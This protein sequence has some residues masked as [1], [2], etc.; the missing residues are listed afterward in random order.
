MF[1]TPQTL[2][3][4]I[5]LG[6]DS[7][8]EL[9][10]VRFRGKKIAGPSRDELAN[11]LAAFANANG[12]VMVLGVDDKTR[13]VAGIP[14]EKLDDVETYVRQI[15]NDAVAP[16]LF[17]KIVRMELPDADGGKRPILKI[18]I[19]QS[20]FVHEGPGGYF[21]RLGSS[22]R[23]MP[24]D[25]LARLF[26]Q[27]SQ[28]RLIRF[29]EQPAPETDRAT[30][31]EYLWRRFIPSEET[32]PI[33]A[34]KKMRLLTTDDNGAERASVAGV[35]MCSE[36]PE[37]ILPNAYIEAVRYRG[38]QRDADHQSAAARITG[39]LDR[40]VMHALSFVRVNMR[41]AAVKRPGRVEFPQFSI[42]AVFEALVNAVGHRDYTIHGS[43]IRLF[44]YDDRL[45]LFS[46]GPPPNTVTPE[47]LH[48]RQA[49]RNELI[50][51]LF[52]RCPMDMYEMDFGRQF[53]MEKRGEGVPII[54]RE[55]ERLSGKPAIYALIDNTELLLTLPSGQLPPDKSTDAD[56]Q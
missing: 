15:C 37:R 43:K 25:V 7:L 19:P 45:E 18:D 42:R 14:L 16:P 9:K 2:L 13:E 23:K 36:H 11:E 44:L 1:D 33:L 53:L 29:D 17:A 5:R 40:Q 4:K 50:A 3:E 20:L 41:V 48:L 12:G 32:D 28:A 35:L 27:R 56:T 55:T 21:Q 10:S 51:S 31:A 47:N 54:M 38:D 49:T 30:L 22:K 46:P 6:E 34:L 39:P 52:S 8:L 24:P 26:Q